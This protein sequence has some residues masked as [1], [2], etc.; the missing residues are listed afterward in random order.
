MSER[1][2]DPDREDVYRVAGDALRRLLEELKLFTRARPVE[3]VLAAFVLGLL[4][5]L[6]GRRSR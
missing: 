1:R 2:F 5:A 6:W 4:A 3:S